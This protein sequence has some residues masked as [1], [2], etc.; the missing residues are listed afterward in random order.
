MEEEQEEEQEE[1]QLLSRVSE[2]TRVIRTFAEILRHQRSF[3]QKRFSSVIS[4]QEQLCLISSEDQPLN[5]QHNP[6]ICDNNIVLIC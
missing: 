5:V 1:D 2:V 3:I 6:R 4:D